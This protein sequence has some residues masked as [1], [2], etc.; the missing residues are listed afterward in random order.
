[1]KENLLIRGRIALITRNKWGRY[2]G[3]EVVENTI[4]NQLKYQIAK[5]LGDGTT[6]FGIDSLFTTN[7]NQSGGGEDGNDGVVIS[8][9]TTAYTMITTKASG[10]TG[11]ENTISFKG[12]FTAPAGGY[13]ATLMYLGRALDWIDEATPFTNFQFATASISKSLA[14]D[15]QLTAYW[16]LTFG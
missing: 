11:S 8:D 9:G 13:T 7:D 4:G 1:M 14:E 5:A 15:D 12:I 6:D 16:D 2:T 10:G 3:Y